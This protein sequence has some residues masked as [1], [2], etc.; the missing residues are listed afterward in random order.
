MATT[1]RIKS[2][3]TG[4]AGAPLTLRASEI[5]FN[6]VDD[7]LYYGKGEDVSGNATSIIKIASPV[8]FVSTDTAQTITGSKTFNQII[9]STNNLNANS[10]KI[11]NLGAPTADGDAVNKL[12]VDSVATGLAIKASCRLATTGNVTLGS[13]PSTIDS[14]TIVTN[15]RILVKDQTDAAQNGIY[16]YNGTSLVRSSDADTSGEV[17]SGMFTFITEGTINSNRGYVLSTPAP[18]VLDTTLLTFTQFSDSGNILA[19]TGLTKS[20]DIISLTGQSLALHNLATAG[21]VT[22]LS[23]GSFAGRSVLG[24]NNRTTIT[25]GTGN[26]GNITVDISAAYVGQNTIT[27]VGTIT[28]GTWNGALI[29]VA[30]GGLNRNTSSD[31]DGT[32]YKKV[33]TAFVPAIAGT[34]YLAANSTI[35]G[36]TIS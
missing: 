29:P 5:A 2:R 32:L 21:L 31:A 25:N 14:V 7:S 11:I 22:R 35:T 26:A 4:S 23:D 18:I 1:V 13:P 28:D 15:D 27:T 20:G 30:Y 36:G 24:V 8:S 10:L 33:G 3:K 12:Y 16:T 17:T 9:L 34:D 19:G 6:E